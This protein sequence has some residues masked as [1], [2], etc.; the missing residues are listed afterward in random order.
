L[1]GTRRDLHS[2]PTRRSSDLVAP[3]QHE[4]G[5]E[6]L[7]GHVVA[8]DHMVVCADRADVV[9]ALL[10]LDVPQPEALAIGVM[11]DLVMA[12]MEPVLRSEERTSELQSR[13]NLV[14]RL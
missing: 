12:G 1:P 2:L 4:D 8:G 11:A 6:R 10:E 9:D 5:A 7:V 13:E 3:M 14:C